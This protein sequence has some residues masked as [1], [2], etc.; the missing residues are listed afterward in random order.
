MASRLRP[1]ARRFFQAYERA[2]VMAL[3]APQPRAQAVDGNQRDQDKVGL[4]H[5]R[6]AL[7][8]HDS[9][10]PGSSGSPARN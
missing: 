5:R 8:L 6:A 9:E 3:A 7:G 4:D 1:V 2:V 10:R